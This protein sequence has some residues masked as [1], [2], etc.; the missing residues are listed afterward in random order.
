MKSTLHCD[1]TRVHGNRARARLPPL[2]GVGRASSHV[3]YFMKH[4][5]NWKW[6]IQ[7]VVGLFFVRWMETIAL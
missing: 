2:L 5:I 4:M 7:Y 1:V 6:C 3:N